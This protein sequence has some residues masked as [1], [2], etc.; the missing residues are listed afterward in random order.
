MKGRDTNDLEVLNSL[1]QF[2]HGDQAQVEE[3]AIPRN[4]HFIYSESSTPRGPAAPMGGLMPAIRSLSSQCVVSAQQP[5]FRICH[6]RRPSCSVIHI[7]IP[8]SLILDLQ[9]TCK[10]GTETRRSLACSMAD[11]AP[12]LSPF[13][14]PFSAI[15]AAN[16]SSMYFS[17]TGGTFSSV[18][19]IV[20]R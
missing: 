12:H 18:A 20:I 3:D 6:I 1:A 4:H 19:L 15:P 13:S 10:P 17:S 2:R 5:L 8:Y 14:Y 11:Y 7:S 9:M 16:F